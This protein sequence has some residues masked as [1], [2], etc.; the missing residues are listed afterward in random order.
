MWDEKCAYTNTVLDHQIKKH[1][2][3]NIRRS[4][5]L[6]TYARAI[7]TSS[8]AWRVAFIE[9]YIVCNVRQGEVLSYLE[10]FIQN[11]I[12]WF[13]SWG[14]QS[15]L[16]TSQSEETV[17]WY[18]LCSWRDHFLVQAKFWQKIG[19]AVRIMRRRRFFAALRLNGRFAAN[20]LTCA[21]TILLRRLSLRG[22]VLSKVS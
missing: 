1:C 8:V 11:T 18:S 21:K 9:L 5:S 4:P 3:K 17:H 15:I 19:E 13:Q 22:H 16:V 7:V 12:F 14:I 2:L 10:N 20:T 6:G